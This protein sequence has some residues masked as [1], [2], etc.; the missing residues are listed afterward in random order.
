M[1]QAVNAKIALKISLILFVL[2]TAGLSCLAAYQGAILESNLNQQFETASLSQSEML[3]TQMIGGVKWKKADTISQTFAKFVIDKNTPLVGVMVNDG[4]GNNLVHHELAERMDVKFDELFKQWKD[5]LDTRA[6][7]TDSSENHFI[8]GQA[9]INEKDNTIMGYAILVWS[10]DAVNAVEAAA[11]RKTLLSF[12]AF[13]AVLVTALLIAVRRSVVVPL[14]GIGNAMRELSQGQLDVAI[15]YQVRTDEIGQMSRALEVFKQNAQRNRELEAETARQ[16][17]QAEQERRA[18]L[19]SMADS[20]DAAV[21]DVIGTVATLSLELKGSAATMTHLADDTATHVTSVAAAAQE[22]AVNVQTVASAAEEL[23][24]SIK[25]I[26]R[27]ITLS[28]QSVRDTSD[29]SNAMQGKVKTLS[30]S[31]EHVGEIISLIQKIAEQTNLLALNATIEAARAG[32]AGRGF[33]IVASE[34]KNLASQTSKATDDIRE[35]ITA[36]QS[37]TQD[38]VDAIDTIT[39]GVASIDGATT[40]VAA[41]MEEQQAATSEIARNVQEASHGTDI[42]T[43]NISAVSDT[44]VEVGSSARAVLNMSEKLEAQSEKLQ[45]EVHKFM[46]TIRA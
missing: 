36:I 35:Q 5:K 9:I 25:E 17:I 24:S 41:A 30:Q 31:A 19:H 6:A 7:V 18:S 33:A 14:V 37:A 40:A 11:T 38:V 2:V 43:K 12:A 13:M 28:S 34:V 39:G 27:Q 32:D 29:R 15:P 26:S 1:F 16:K 45:S 4:E 8:Y 42:V 20:F 44:A 10:K 3:V 21:G 23:S 46:A 22:A